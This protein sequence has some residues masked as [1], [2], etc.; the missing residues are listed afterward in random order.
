MTKSKHR[1]S[2][3]HEARKVVTWLNAGRS[4]GRLRVAEIVELYNK[5]GKSTPQIWHPGDKKTGRGAMYLRLQKLLNRYTYKFKVI[6]QHTILDSATKLTGDAFWESFSVLNVQRLR[7][8]D[9]IS[10][11]KRCDGCAGWM[12]AR[13]PGQRF[14]SESCRIKTYQSTPEW[15][16]RNNAARRKL[17][18]LRKQNG[19][20]RYQER[21][22]A[23]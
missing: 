21:R 14:C 12:F 8:M 9:L 2:G 19:K 6:A 11:V 7:Q 16:A 3:E 20:I 17:Y 1:F 5:L 18:H 13:L 10:R 15:R 4:A 22:G 23:L